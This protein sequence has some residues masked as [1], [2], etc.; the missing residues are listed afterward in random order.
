[1]KKYPKLRKLRAG[2]NREKYNIAFA[3]FEKR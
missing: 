3:I 2:S 1:M